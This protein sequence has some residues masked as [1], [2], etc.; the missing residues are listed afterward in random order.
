[1]QSVSGQQAPGAGEEDAEGGLVCSVLVPS[2][3]KGPQSPVVE[4]TPSRGWSRHIVPVTRQRR[5]EH[6][7]AA[8]QGAQSRSIPRWKSGNAARAGLGLLLVFGIWFKLS[9]DLTP[10]KATEQRIWQFDFI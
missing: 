5:A 3:D 10:T 2:R 7:Q 6:L 1:M 9:A 4:R 8:S